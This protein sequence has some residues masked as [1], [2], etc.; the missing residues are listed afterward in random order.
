MAIKYARRVAEGFSCYVIPHRTLLVRLLG[1]LGL[2]SR[3]KH[4]IYLVTVPFFVQ[5][6]DHERKYLNEG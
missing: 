5:D 1:S 2:D 6:D 3:L 4:Q